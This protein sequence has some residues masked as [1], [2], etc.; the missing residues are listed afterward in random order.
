MFPGTDWV[1]E[2]ISQFT[3]TDGL[4]MR[5]WED[6]VRKNGTVSAVAE[7]GQ[8]VQEIPVEKTEENIQAFA[9]K[10]LEKYNT[11]RMELARYLLQGLNFVNGQ[12]QPLQMMKPLKLDPALLE[13]PLYH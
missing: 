3:I 6:M 1:R 13:Q 5:S 12:G 11:R 9:Q 4:I 2:K 8:A 7:T 10:I